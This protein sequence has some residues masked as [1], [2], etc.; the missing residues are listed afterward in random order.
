MRFKGLYFKL[1][2]NFSGRSL[3]NKTIYNNY[4]PYVGKTKR[5]L[6]VRSDEHLRYERD[7]LHCE[8]KTHL[9]LC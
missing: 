1:Y 9:R 6:V 5:H 2:D 4:I 8:I 7:Q 3:N